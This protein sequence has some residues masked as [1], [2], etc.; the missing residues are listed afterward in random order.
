M[1]LKLW[2]QLNDRKIG[3]KSHAVL[4]N[5]SNINI[6]QW[7]K[8]SSN[9][10]LRFLYMFNRFYTRRLNFFKIQT[11]LLERM[12]NYVRLWRHNWV[13]FSVDRVFIAEIVT[14]YFTLRLS[15]T[16]TVWWG[17]WMRYTHK[18]WEWWLSCLR[19]VAKSNEALVGHIIR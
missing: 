16:L 17:E 18:D 6:E 11:I 12:V 15:S 2:V 10:T 1:Y 3:S 13:E 9:I 4:K 5:W 19:S 8:L 14:N 7:T